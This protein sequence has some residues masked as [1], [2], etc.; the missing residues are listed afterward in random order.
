MNHHTQ[1]AHVTHRSINEP[2]YLTFG[3]CT[4][5][6]GWYS[7][8]CVC[9]HVCMYKFASIAC[10]KFKYLQVLGTHCTCMYSSNPTELTSPL[11]SAPRSEPAPRI[12][13]SLCFRMH[14]HVNIFIT[15]IHS[16]THAS[17]SSNE[18]APR[19]SKSL[20]FRMCVRVRTFM[21]TRTNSHTCMHACMYLIQEASPRHESQDL[22][23]SVCIFV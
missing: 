17:T 13:K 18:P 15:H 7:S 1:Y 4:V 22:S 6:I 2:S 12:S 19:I 23:V 14:M 10:C 8:T 21:H 3:Q 20:C 11:W 9:M 5:H 16:C